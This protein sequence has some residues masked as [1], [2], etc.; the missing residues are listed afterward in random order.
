MAMTFGP[1]PMPQGPVLHSAA[2]LV[3]LGVGQT[4]QMERIGHPGGFQQSV[5][6]TQRPALSVMAP[7]AGAI[8]L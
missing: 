3:Q 8:C 7:R 6:V 1:A 2:A 4:N 5:R